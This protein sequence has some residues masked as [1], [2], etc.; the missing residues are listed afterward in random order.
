MKAHKNIAQSQFATTKTLQEQREYLPV[1][2]VREEVH[3]VIR[4][5]HIVVPRVLLRWIYGFLS[6]WA[7]PKILEIFSLRM[8]SPEGFPDLGQRVGGCCSN[9]LPFL[10]VI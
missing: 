6:W 4:E 10:R 9:G 1:Y 3:N 2:N 5:D 7:I 8:R